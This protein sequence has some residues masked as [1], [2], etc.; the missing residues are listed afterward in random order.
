MTEDEYINVAELTRIR[1]ALDLLSQINLD[2]LAT[3]PLV[4][5]FPILRSLEKKMN[6]R[7]KFEEKNLDQ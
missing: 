1:V 6:Q 3:R 2:D 4:R 7:I 5:V